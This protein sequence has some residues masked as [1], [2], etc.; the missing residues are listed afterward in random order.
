MATQLSAGPTRSRGSSTQHLYQRLSTLIMGFTAFDES[1]G[2]KRETARERCF[3]MPE[4]GAQF[5]AYHYLLANITS[6]FQQGS[7]S[8]R[9][10]IKTALS[11]FEE[12]ERECARSNE[13]LVDVL[14]KP[15]AEQYRR[16]L[17][18]ARRIVSEVL[19][20]YN[21]E[22]LPGHCAFSSGASTEA[23]RSR[24]MIQLKWD[25]ASHITE[26]ALPYY[27]AYHKWAGVMPPRELVIV[28]GNEVFTVPKNY[29]RD[30]VCA[31]EP[32]WNM[33]FQKGV[34]GY[35]R[36]RLRKVGLLH[37]DAQETHATL[38]AKASVTGSMATLDLKAASDTI[39]LAI[40][41]VLV[42]DDWKRVIYD[43]R[44]PV[45][46]LPNGDTCL[47]E[48]I[49]SMGNGFTFELETLLFYALS[50][51][52]CEQD[53]LVSVYGDDIIA[54]TCRASRIVSL[55]RF[56]G[57]ETN[58][59]K[60]FT[61]GLFRESCGG[62]YYS[63][64]DVKPFY[65]HQ[66]PSSLPQVINLHNDIVAWIGRTG[67]KLSRLIDIAREC[68]RLIP[69]K[70]WGPL[71]TDGCLWAEWDEATPKYVRGSRSRN[72]PAYGHW[73]VSTIRPKVVKQ[74]HDYL[75]GGLLASLAPIGDE[76]PGNVSEDFPNDRRRNAMS[77]REVA[78]RTNCD[79][80]RQSEITFET[81]EYVTGWVAVG[82][83]RQWPCLP[84]RLA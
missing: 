7:V 68:R 19:G 35:I 29:E 82:V 84:V 17:L 75:V 41:D 57:F 60:T 63:G 4:R 39:S 79:T 45:G 76:L 22:L 58:T 40:V 78:L 83:G 77:L 18:R 32:S 70:Y 2:R 50:K 80:V 34:G 14:N 24:S 49:S 15:S 31:K 51:A 62:H 21:P 55:L 3:A 81:T 25:E 65:V 67:L 48:K 26:K 73:R 59:D 1:L 69:R 12:A 52:C 72:L 47:Y 71:G 44:S 16:R 46:L 64:F 36:Q 42:P 13:R 54:P 38:A 74:N 53:E 27:L 37:P 6:K 11:K 23:N 28:A 33:F 20:R 5:F 43:L 8:S 9:D 56:C 61:E 10:R 30:R 66:L